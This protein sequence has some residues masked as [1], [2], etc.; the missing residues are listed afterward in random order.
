MRMDMPETVMTESNS[1]SG[2]PSFRGLLLSEQVRV[3]LQQYFDRVDGLEISGLH[4]LV[5]GEV[6]RPL[7]E[8]V[9]ERCGHNQS[10]AALILGLSR[11]TLRKKISYYGLD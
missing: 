3:A 8:A 11:S 4:A 1:A 5:I 6:E 7:I 10:R 9:M 2:D